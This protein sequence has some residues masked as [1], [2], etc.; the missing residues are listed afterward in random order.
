MPGRVFPKKEGAD[1]TSPQAK[2]TQPQTQDNKEEQMAP[3]VA[4]EG[5]PPRAK[6]THPQTQD[7][8]DNKDQPDNKDNK[9][10]PMGA[11]GNAH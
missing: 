5:T 2:V 4:A 9:D 3:P 10:Q 7:N 1:G 11:V 8:K 6:V